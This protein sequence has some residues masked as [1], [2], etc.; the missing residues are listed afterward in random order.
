LARRTSIPDRECDAVTERLLMAAYGANIAVFVAV[1][2]VFVRYWQ[3]QRERLFAFFAVAFWCFAI[4]FVIRLVT[5]VE[6]DRAFVFI[7]RLIGFLLIIVAI[8]DK[9][10]R[11]AR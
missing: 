8:F 9:N 3:N 2:L 11:A 4:G 10:R 1:G 7:P 6:E 5:G